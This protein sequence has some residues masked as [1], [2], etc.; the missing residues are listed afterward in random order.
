MLNSE[1][2]LPAYDEV[3]SYEAAVAGAGCTYRLLS[4]YTS[5]EDRYPLV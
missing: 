3:P 1:S 5:A 2:A 4:M